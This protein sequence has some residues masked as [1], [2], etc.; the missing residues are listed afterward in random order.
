LLLLAIG[1]IWPNQLGVLPTVML[2]LW[3]LLAQLLR[4]QYPLVLAGALQRRSL[5]GG[6]VSIQEPATRLRSARG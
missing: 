1:R 5:A 4:Q 3:L 6:L 2:L